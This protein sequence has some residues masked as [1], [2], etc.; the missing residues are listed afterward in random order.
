MDG[1]FGCVCGSGSGF[2]DGFLGGFGLGYR[3]SFVV[4]FGVLGLTA[5]LADCGVGLVVCWF[6]DLGLGGLVICLCFCAFCGVGIIWVWGNCGVV[7]YWLRILVDVAHW[8]CVL[9]VAAMG[10][11]GLALAAW[12][13]VWACGLRRVRWVFLVG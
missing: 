12:R 1:G 4:V 3:L 13:V 7:A 6:G 10:F 11:V 2:R 5:L 8:L 9:F